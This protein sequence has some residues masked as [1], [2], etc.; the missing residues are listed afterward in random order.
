M[1]VIESE[2][3]VRPAVRWIERLCEK[4]SMRRIIFLYPKGEAFG[5]LA[6]HELHPWERAG[7]NAPSA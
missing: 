6:F 1:E 2:N 3:A 4:F 7:G 5:K